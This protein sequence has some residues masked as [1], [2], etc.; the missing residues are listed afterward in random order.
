M[1]A[2]WVIEEVEKIVSPVYLV[3]GS[4]RDMLL[5]REPK[6][7]DFCTPLSPDEIE[8]KV[9]AA[10]RRAY[11]TGKRFGTIGFVL[12]LKTGAKGLPI[13]ITTF[14]TERYKPGSRKPEVEFVSDLKEDLARRDFTFNAIALQ[15][16]EYFDPFGGRMDIL[17]EKI[18]SVGDA[19]DRFKEDPLRMLRAARFAAQLGFEIDP[20]MIGKIRKMP[21][22]ILGISRER[23]VQEMDKLL[24]A[25]HPEAGLKV[26][27]D[28][29]LLKYMIP[30]V[31]AIS[32]DNYLWQELC[33][34]LKASPKDADTRWAV[35]LMD[36]AKPITRQE[37]KAT[38]GFHFAP[39]AT[40]RH[41]NLIGLGI[42]TGISLR[43]KF[44]NDR[45]KKIQE[46][47]IKERY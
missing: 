47:T 14:R 1:N 33:V 30:E 38:R 24:V 41:S 23:W 27:V 34:K 22:T 4:V 25:E 9:I 13:E 42:V 35:L 7:Y 29:Y 5:E 11:S 18:K 20:N 46:I 19:T 28:S 10:G 21:Q 8:A 39:T 15:N 36:I 43:L 32:Q 6:D 37:I 44:S 26:L 16:K 31:W 17:A 12:P 40:Y 3:G 2:E 45:L